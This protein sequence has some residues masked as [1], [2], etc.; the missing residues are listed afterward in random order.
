MY[1]IR[2]DPDLGVGKA[3]VRMIPCSCLFCTERL[4]LT[5]DKNEENTNQRRYGINKQ[6]LN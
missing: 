1:N 3:T 6:C 2:C 5:W 4:N